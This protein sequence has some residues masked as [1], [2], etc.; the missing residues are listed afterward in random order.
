MCIEQMDSALKSLG[1]ASFDLYLTVNNIVQLVYQI[2]GND[3]PL[4]V[5]LSLSIA[6]QLLLLLGLGVEACCWSHPRFRHKLSI[7]MFFLMLFIAVVN[8][9]ISWLP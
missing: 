4:V 3:I 2:K 5:L 6:L 1:V 8:C 7:V 9:L